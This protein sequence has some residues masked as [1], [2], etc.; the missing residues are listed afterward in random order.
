MILDA[1]NL[2]IELIKKPSVSPED[3]GCIDLIVKYLQPYG[4]QCEIFHCEG[5]TNLWATH[6]T[7]SPC[8]S[9]IGHTDVVPPGE[10]TLW[11]TPPFEP[12]IE[13]NILYGRGACDMKG[14]LAA[15]V[16]AA[17]EYVQQYPNHAGTLAFI[18]TSDEEGKALFGTRKVVE[19]L[20]NSKKTIEYALVGE[21]SS[22]NQLADTIKIGRRG[23]LTGNL[24]IQGIQG[25]VAYP[26][27]AKN[28][29]HQA[30]EVL[31]TLTQKQ[32]GDEH[33]D[34]PLTSLQFS[35]IQAGTGAD[36]VIPDSLT[37]IFNFRYNPT[38]TH[39][40]LIASFEQE[41]QNNAINY[42]V[43]WHHS[44]S[45]FITSRNSK[46]LQTLLETLKEQKYPDPT[47]STSGGTSDGRFLGAIG[48]EVVEIGPVNKTI[49]Q[50]NECVDIEQL[51]ALQKIYFQVFR[52][53]LIQ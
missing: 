37:T 27:L 23:S 5:V 1:I 20:Q 4:F 3:A 47:L 46:L 39:T 16:I 51:K 13:D 41:L 43:E 12:V 31:H 40:E 30:F 29:I 28:P 52:R 44:G 6:G 7:Q 48:T 25:H 15:M 36:N 18:I 49:H 50:I 19:W 9:L 42:T 34:F 2:A 33:P 26:Q 38:I 8:L 45:P 10:E 35:N 17:C 22:V 21:P 53:I 32:W 11:S 24:T 14:A